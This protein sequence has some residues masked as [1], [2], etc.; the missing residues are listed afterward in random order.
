MR[1]GG[2]KKDFK[3]MIYVIIFVYVVQS[4]FCIIVLF[5]TFNQQSYENTWSQERVLFQ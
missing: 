5:V 3:E 2:E 1:N 4:F